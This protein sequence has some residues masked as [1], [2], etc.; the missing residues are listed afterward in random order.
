[1]LTAERVALI[2]QIVRQRSSVS[3]AELA[4]QCGTSEVTIRRD[5]AYLEREGVVT[6]VWGGAVLADLGPASLANRFQAHCAEFPEEKAAIGKAAAALVF[7]GET[8]LID[9][10][11][12]ALALVR[13]LPTDSHLTAIVTS[14][15][16]AEELEHMTGI[17]TILTGG[18]LR[19]RATSLVNPMLSKSLESVMASKV[20]LGVRGVSADHGLTSSDFA[21]ADVK[22]ALIAHAREV[23]VL[24]DHSKLGVVAPAF[25]GSLN[26]VR[27][28]V[29]D[30]DASPD[31]LEPLERLGVQIILAGAKPGLTQASGG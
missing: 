8:I 26:Q 5:L 12:T 25:I 10:G 13:H 2:R 9:A 23:I 17:N 16:I 19:E 1:M 7:P 24:A 30:A 20:F 28:L 31:Q 21:E 14:I 4:R 3:V 15:R 18:T 6:R 27:A 22:K 11:S 29:T